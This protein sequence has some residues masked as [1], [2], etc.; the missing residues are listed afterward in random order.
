M[1]VPE[2]KVSEIT[3]TRA[4]KSEENPTNN[5]SPDRVESAINFDEVRNDGWDSELQVLE[6]EGK[7]IPRVDLFE[8]RRE[9]QTCLA[10]AKYKY[11]VPVFPKEPTHDGKLIKPNEAERFDEK[12]YFHSGADKLK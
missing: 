9:K 11:K 1:T 10:F 6:V 7:E 4:I 8:D 3:N 12:N 5:T 2:P